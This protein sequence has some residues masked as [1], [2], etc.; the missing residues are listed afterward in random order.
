MQTSHQLDEF[1]IKL[2]AALQADASATNA[3][4]AD[5]V[6]LSQSQVSRRRLALEAA[7]IIERYRAVLDAQRLGLAIMVFIH[8]SLDTHSRDNARLFQAMVE[9]D[10]NILEAYSLTG[11]ADYF[12][13]VMVEDLTDLSR[14]V[15]EVLLPHPAVARVKSEIVLQTLKK[16]AAIPLKHLARRR[17]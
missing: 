5:A 13:K 2:L 6:G 9:A 14:V 1:D 12:L 17:T 11:D 8:V 4:L 7:G 10:P 3:E 15:N 16:D